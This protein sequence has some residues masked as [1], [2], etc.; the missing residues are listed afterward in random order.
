MR[1]LPIEVRCEAAAATPKRQGA[2]TRAAARGESLP[3][4]PMSTG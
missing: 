4:D 3:L 2:A 1:Y